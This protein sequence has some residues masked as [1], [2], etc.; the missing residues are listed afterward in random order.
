MQKETPDDSIVR[1]KKGAYG[2]SQRPKPRRSEMRHVY[3]ILAREIRS[4]TFECW[5]CANEE[6]YD[7]LCSD[8]LTTSA[9]SLLSASLL[10]SV[11]QR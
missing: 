4:K 2:V 6:K 3:R 7:T 5:L 10:L 11:P 8:I 9:S 1:A